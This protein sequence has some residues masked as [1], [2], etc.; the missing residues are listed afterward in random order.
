MQIIISIQIVL[1]YVEQIG[2]NETKYVGSAVHCTLQ[3]TLHYDKLNG[4]NESTYK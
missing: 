3:C 2:Q 4:V 1:I